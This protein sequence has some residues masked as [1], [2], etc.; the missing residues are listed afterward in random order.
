MNFSTNQVMQ[1]YVLEAAPAVQ[2][3]LDGSIRI[4]FKDAAGNVT[5]TSDKIE[6]VMW[7]KLSTADALAKN[8]IKAKLVAT[9]PLIVGQDYIVKVSYPEVAGLGVEGYTTKTASVRVTSST[10]VNDLYTA[11]ARDLNVNFADGMLKASVDGGLVITQT[12]AVEKA[13]KR[14]MRPVVIVDFD[15]YAN[16]VLDE[17]EDVQ[18]ATITKLAGAT[19]KDG[20]AV[21]EMEYFAL[22]ERGDQY[23]MMGWPDV[24]ETE[25]KV[26]HKAEYD[27]LNVHFGYKGANQNSHISE[28]DLVVV[29]P[30]G[31]ET[32]VELA[33]ALELKAGI[34]FTK[35]TATGEA[36]LA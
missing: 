14:G 4:A 28:K 32:L 15:V 30:K 11:L 3:A 19:V 24:I 16:V 34:E 20:Y 8:Y 35:V 25:Y 13:Y 22:G 21:S 6:N 23:R 2:E 1:F 36:A 17:G 10:T 9:E 29:A 7:G 31:S 18:W 12:D 5:A 27:V 33:S 26:D